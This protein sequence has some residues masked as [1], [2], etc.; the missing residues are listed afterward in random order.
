MFA[1]LAFVGVVGLIAGLLFL[2]VGK[3]FWTALVRPL[4]VSLG[5]LPPGEHELLIQGWKAER[6]GRVEDAVATYLGVLTANPGCAAAR[7]RLELLA[8]TH[9]ELVPALPEPP[10]PAVAPPPPPRPEPQSQPTIASLRAAD[11]NEAVR[12][13]LDEQARRPSSPG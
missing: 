2:T 11:L 7:E 6:D 5:L 8:E 9:P 4:V 12:A 3:F 13:F 10:R 1:N